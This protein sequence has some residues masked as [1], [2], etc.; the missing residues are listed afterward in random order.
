M[1]SVGQKWSKSSKKKSS[2]NVTRPIKLIAN[3]LNTKVYVMAV[4]R[5]FF[6]AT[7]QNTQTPYKKNIMHTKH[8][9]HTR[10]AKGSLTLLYLN[11]PQGQCR[12]N[13]ALLGGVRPEGSITPPPPAEVKACPPL[14]SMP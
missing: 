7:C 8:C 9:A 3:L 14:W 5:G 12:E 1:F 13:L 10:E 2:K 6:L 4:K 11:R